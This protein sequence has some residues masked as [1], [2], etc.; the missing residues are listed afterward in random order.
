MDSRTQ[1]IAT[2]GI[3][4]LACAGRAFPPDNDNRGVRVLALQ[5]IVATFAGIDG[6]DQAKVAA[7]RGQPAA[8]S[9]E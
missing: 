8:Q 4:A 1:P 6:A 2:H 9:T 7:E 5:A 3:Q